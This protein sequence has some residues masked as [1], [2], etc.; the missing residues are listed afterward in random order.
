MNKQILFNQEAKEKLKSGIN[1][2]ADAVICTLGPSGRCVSI[3]KEYGDIQVTKDGVTV[4]KSISLSDPVEN[5]GAQM[6]KKAAIKTLE[7]CGDGTTTSTLLASKLVTNGL[8]SIKNGT[9]A[10]DLKRG[11]DKASKLVIEQLKKL[12]KDINDEKQ[13]KQV[14]VIS[15]NN[16][17]EIGNLVAT[18]IQKVGRDGVVT[19]E[20]SK[21]GET[22]LE[23]VEGIQF[24]RGYKSPHF[25]T[26]Q[27]NMSAVLNEVYILLYDRKINTAKEILP[28]LERIS[29]ENKQLLIIAEDI[30]GEALAMLVLNKVRGALKVCAVKAPDFGERRK[31]ILEDIAILTGGQVISEDKGMQLVDVD[32][33]HLGYARLATVTKDETTIVDG[34]GDEEKIKNRL[35]SI[36]YQIDNSQSDFEIE[37]LQER[38]AKLIGGV[39]II[40]V[41]GANDLEIKEKKDRVDDALQA[42]KASLEQGVL[43]GGGIALIHASKILLDKNMQKNMNADELL[44]LNIVYQVMFDPFIQILQNAGYSYEKIYGLS[45]TISKNKNIW[46]GFNPKSNKMTNMFDE[47]IL[48]PTKVTITALE[49]AVSI[50]GTILITEAVIVNEKDSKDQNNSEMNFEM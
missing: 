45:Y 13:I 24:S 5:M 35:L 33:Q 3:E 42:T 4:A 9:N 38:L 8:N 49:N 34:K 30:D 7:K 14:A 20:E 18:A 17:D 50:A 48:D 16:D 6:V 27:N 39:A 44:G 46:K 2:L 31:E 25:V 29:Q 22:S 28:I 12:S 10:T 32:I 37:K 11:M 23:I 21:I 40:N 47:G 19:V 43:P 26:N 15:S 36:K 1:K 41:G